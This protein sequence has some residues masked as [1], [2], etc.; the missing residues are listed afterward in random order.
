[1]LRTYQLVAGGRVW[2]IWRLCN[3]C[4][5]SRNPHDPRATDPLDVSST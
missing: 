3:E 5:I 4:L 1:M 2:G